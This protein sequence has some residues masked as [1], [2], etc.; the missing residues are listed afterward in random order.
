MPRRRP[1]TTLLLVVSLLLLAAPATVGAAPALP[2]S[3]A[4]AGDSITRAFN[5]CRFPFMDCPAN[6]WSTGTSTTVNSH[7]LRI[8]GENR[9]IR[10][11][12]YN[13]ARSGAKMAD[14]P[15]Q[16][17]TISGRNV[18]YVTVQMGGNDVCTSSLD[19]M[20]SVESFDASFRAA[21]E[22]ISANS[23]VT[24]VYVTS[25]PDAHRLWEIL[26]A[27]PKAVATWDRY[28]VCQSLLAT[29][30]DAAADAARRAAVRE[31]NKALN[32]ALEDACRTYAKCVW[33][34]WAVFCTQFAA[35]DVSTR[36]YF[37][38]SV[39]GQ[40]KLAD[41]SWRAGPFVAEPTAYLGSDCAP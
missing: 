20:T 12:N 24:T 23:A 10:G 34:G 40:A 2:N 27:D 41:V 15:G 31:H 21:M 25:V 9:K 4:A 32:Q 11:K 35:G 1:L 14:L 18:Q 8:L 13:D 7:Y 5:T 38:P 17:S 6:S 36:D 26:H 33:D 28:D 19:T 37:H 16:M 30:S 3:M 22:T 29:T 39:S